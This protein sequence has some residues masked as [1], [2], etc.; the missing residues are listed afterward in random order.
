MSRGK[1]SSAQACFPQLDNAEWT[2]KLDSSIKLGKILGIPIGVNYSWIFVFVLFIFLLARQYSQSH[3]GWDAPQIWS[4]ALVTTVLFFL[5]V[6]A[7]EMSHSLLAVRKGI[8]V[9]GITLFVF[10]GVSQLSHEAR[11]PMTEFLIAVVIRV[12]RIGPYQRAS[13]EAA[14][15]GRRWRMQGKV[16]APN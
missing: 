5:S 2:K 8:P 4:T 14:Y 6:V 13:R 12:K 7:H 1:R 9:I 16:V 10:G 15:H 3:L 11:R